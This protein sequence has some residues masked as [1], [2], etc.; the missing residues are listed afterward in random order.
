MKVSPG[1]I[2]RTVDGWS[3]SIDS[4]DISIAARALGRTIGNHLLVIAVN[5]HDVCVLSPELGPLWV[6]NDDRRMIVMR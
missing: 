3:V 1:D 2:V 5:L 6:K 4:N